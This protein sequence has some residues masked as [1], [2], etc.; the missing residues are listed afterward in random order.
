MEAGAG[1]VLAD[2]KQVALDIVVPLYNE[3]RFHMGILRLHVYEGSRMEARDP[4]TRLM[5]TAARPLRAPGGSHRPW[6]G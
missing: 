4:M 5:L 2:T 3:E 1:Q 6:L